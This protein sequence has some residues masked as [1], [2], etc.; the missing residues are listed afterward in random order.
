MSDQ[1][2]DFPSD[3]NGLFGDYSFSDS[4]FDNPTGLEQSQKKLQDIRPITNSYFRTSY[5]IPLADIKK[6]VSYTEKL[7]FETK[8]IIEDDLL[9]KI[10]I[11]PYVDPDLEQAHF[12]MWDEASRYLSQV[13][14]NTD[15]LTSAP[16]YICFDQYVFAEKIS[17]TAG[18]R[19]IEEYRE[20]IAHSTFSY[21]F[22][23]RRMLMLVMSELS[24]IKKSLLSDFG[25]GYENESQQKVASQYYSWCKMATDYAQRIKKTIASVP[26]KVPASEVDKIGKKQAAQF[27]TFFSI[28]LNAVDSE[29]SNILSS[30]Q[31]D[32]VDNCDIF[33]DNYLR[34][35]IRLNKDIASPLELERET[36]NHNEMFPTL[37]KEIYVASTFI[38]GNFVSIQA[39]MLE[40]FSMFMEKMDMVMMLVHEK[41]KY[42]NFIS[43]LSYKAVKKKAVLKNIE[44]DNYSLFFRNINVN[45]KRNDTYGSSHSDLDGLDSNDHPQYLLR[46]GGVITGNISTEDNVTIDGVDIGSHAHTGVD[47]SARISIRDIDFSSVRD[48]DNRNNYAIKPLSV[49]VITF[50]PD[51]IEGGVPVFDT[52]IGIEI[53]D[54]ITEDYE[55]EISYIE[56]S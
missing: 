15:S 34:P 43:Q 1:I 28:K 50:I 7:V 2:Q 14:I 39:D 45:T 3:K 52:V 38:K 42:S 16:D 53:D 22:N 23:F 5:T 29:I 33:Y 36:T 31:R 46:S 51:V 12:R 4:F 21:L 19:L 25:G 6:H 13:S 18:R 44:E 11:D 26:R 27:Q 17:S 40:R 35:S 37:S 30:L 10:Y 9:R 56:I 55:Y 24:C 8:K 54:S 32:M 49:R 20:A 48:Q 47:G 41:R